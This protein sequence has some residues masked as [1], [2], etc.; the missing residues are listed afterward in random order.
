MFQ[1]S[2]V[3]F[4]IIGVTLIYITSRHQR[5][6]S[7]PHPKI[8]SILGACLLL[9]SLLSWWQ[10]L[11]VTAAIFAWLFTIITLFMCIPFST[12]LKSRRTN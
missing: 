9:F 11:T 7:I 1:I 5:L 12:L 4:S 6:L 10:L 2:A 3:L 8:F